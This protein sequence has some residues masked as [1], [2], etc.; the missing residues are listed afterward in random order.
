MILDFSG[1]ALQ[2]DAMMPT[3]RNVSYSDAVADFTQTV[4][5]YG[6]V[7]DSVD[8]SGNVQRCSTD[9]KPHKQNGWLRFVELDNGY[10]YGSFGNWRESEDGHSWKSWTE[11]SMT[12]QERDRLKQKINARKNQ[13]QKE[14]ISEQQEKSEKLSAYF[15]G[16][17][18]ALDHPYKEKKRINLYGDVRIDQKENCLVIPLQSIDGNLVGVQRIYE[19]KKR[20]LG[21][22]DRTPIRPFAVLPAE[23]NDKI[24][25]VEGFATAASVREATGCTTIAAITARRLKVIGETIRSQFKKSELIFVADNDLDNAKG[26][27][28]VKCARDAALAVNG[29]VIIPD[30]NGEPLDANDVAVKFGTEMLKALL[31]VDGKSIYGV[32][33][34]KSICEREYPHNPVIEGLLDEGECVIIGGDS[35]LGKSIMTLHIAAMCGNPDLETPAWGNGQINFDGP[36]MLFGHFPILSMSRS[37]F[38]QDENSGKSI[39]KRLGL[40]SEKN[41][42]IRKGIESENILTLTK[43]EDGNP[44]ANGSLDDPVLFRALKIHILKEKIRLLIVDPL[45]SYHGAADENANVEML[46][47][48]NS[49][50]GRLC[51]ETNV[52]VILVHHTSKDG[53]ERGVRGASSIK[54]WCDGLMLGEETEN[55]ENGKIIKMVYAKSRNFERRP[56]EF[57]IKMDQNL[58]FHLLDDYEPQTETGPS[59]RSFADT[60]DVVSII[61][62]NVEFFGKAKLV[63]A[64]SEKTHASKASCKKAVE[65]AVDCNMICEESQGHMKPARYTLTKNQ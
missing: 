14:A 51:E 65:K 64:L 60:T 39:Q 31:G 55:D 41:E 7:V 58:D 28:G 19:D 10:Y 22:I 37:M 17:P 20:T 4:R 43:G 50:F 6:L 61:G 5:E 32:T 21:V 26:N 15:H 12:Q 9:D 2:Q 34:L 54:G 49:T 25:I 38:L 47:A 1:E 8:T 44:C 53:I 36:P 35:N 48:L 59:S 29:T 3:R 13:E 16:L 40:M 46:K 23:N 27:I 18:Q 45:S 33:T 42:M 56:S 63:N 11:Q 62:E 57:Y 24:Y 52:A 30:V